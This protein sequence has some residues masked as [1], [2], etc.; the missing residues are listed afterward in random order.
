MRPERGT[1]VRRI[2]RERRVCCEMSAMVTYC[3]AIFFF[4]PTFS[5]QSIVDMSRK[6]RV[7]L[8]SREQTFWLG[9]STSIPCNYIIGDGHVWKLEPV[10]PKK[11]H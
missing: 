5:M 11:R 3:V 10:Q 1:V 7:D 6:L 9:R 4:N 2:E 8:R